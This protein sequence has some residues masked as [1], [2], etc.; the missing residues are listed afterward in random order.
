MAYGTDSG[1]L[2][3]LKRAAEELYS[4]PLNFQELA[5]W[6]L[7]AEDFAEDHVYVWPD[8]WRAVEFFSSIGPGAWNVG[9]GG[10]IGIRP[11]SFREVRLAVGIKA[12][13]WRDMYADI[14]AMENAALNR[15]RR[16]IKNG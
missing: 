12:D 5:E 7:K 10:P 16:E 4:P 8:N 9:M 1:P 2:G 13:E 11:E 6:G 3:K 14:R 15:M